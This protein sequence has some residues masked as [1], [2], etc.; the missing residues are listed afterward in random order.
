MLL[1][2]FLHILQPPAATPPPASTHIPPTTAPTRAPHTLHPHQ[3]A[4]PPPTSKSIPPPTAPNRAPRTSV[5]VRPTSRTYNATQPPVMGSSRRKKSSNIWCTT[6]V[7]VLLDLY[8]DKWISINRGN[9]K[10]K[11]WAEIS[12]DIHAQRGIVF[13]ESQCKNKWENMKK[14]FMKEK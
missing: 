2:V 13:S 10:A 14:T 9:F 4:T 5:D 7:S 11:H 3:E 1:T 12:R 8:E 6:D